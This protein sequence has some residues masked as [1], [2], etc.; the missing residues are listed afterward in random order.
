[1]AMIK[2]VTFLFNHQTQKKICEFTGAS[3]ILEL[4]IANEVPLNHSCGGMGS[5]TT[6]LVKVQKGLET[7]EPRNELEAEHANMRNFSDNERLSCQTE[8]KDGLVLEV[9]SVDPDAI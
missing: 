4:A 5:C 8:A 1:M 7:L 9:P 2:K 3:S 6:C